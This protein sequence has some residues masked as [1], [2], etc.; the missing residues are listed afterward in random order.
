[1]R[2]AKDFSVS[3]FRFRRFYEISW[4]M[5]GKKIKGGKAKSSRFS[6]A[7]HLLGL[8]VVSLV[9]FGSSDMLAYHALLIASYSGLAGCLF[10][11]LI[12]RFRSCDSVQCS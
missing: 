9:R 7:G 12:L 3:I 8:V 11:G 5:M 4:S 6:L 2:P 1:M 10:A